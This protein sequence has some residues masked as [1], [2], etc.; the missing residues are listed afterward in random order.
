M[1][2]TFPIIQCSPPPGKLA[3]GHKPISAGEEWPRGPVSGNSHSL[4]LAGTNRGVGVIS[5][6]PTTSQAE[7]RQFLSWQAHLHAHIV[8]AHTHPRTSPCSR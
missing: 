6:T 2:K 5:D 1:I 8:Q 4:G 7:R 3:K